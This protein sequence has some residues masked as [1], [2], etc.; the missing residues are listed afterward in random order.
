VHAELNALQGTWSARDRSA[1]GYRMQLPAA[2]NSQTRKIRTF[3]KVHYSLMYQLCPDS[4]D[5]AA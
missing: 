5:H 2:G 4:Q 3:M 1:C